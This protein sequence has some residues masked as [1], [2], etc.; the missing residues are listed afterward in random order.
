M[1]LLDIVLPLFK[2][3]L[4]ELLVL[5]VAKNKPVLGYMT[6]EKGKLVLKDEK[7]LAG[8]KASKLTPCW[9]S[10]I[11]GMVCDSKNHEWS[12]LTF[13][14]LEKC[15]LA[16][17]LNKTRHGALAEAENQYGDNLLAFIGSVYRGYQL[18]LDNHFLPVVMLRSLRGRD[19]IKG[20]A[21]CDLRAAPIPLSVIRRIHGDVSK[22][23][24]RHLTLGV[25]DVTLNAEQFD[26]MFEE[27]LPDS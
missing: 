14:G 4:G 24:E 11:V 8:K 21:V 27:Y 13:Y 26:A 15:D 7:Y 2:R 19:G 25:E 1:K 20:L 17:D 3:G 22:S 12:S 23:V 6:Y 18:M 16:L 5:H 9:E 10:G